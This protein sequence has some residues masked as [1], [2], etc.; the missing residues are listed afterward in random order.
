MQLGRREQGEE[1]GEAA[2]SLGSNNLFISRFERCVGSVVGLNTRGVVRAGEEEK[3]CIFWL[4][5][6]NTVK[7]VKGGC[8][9]QVNKAG[10]TN[11]WFCSVAAKPSSN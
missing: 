11:F 1:M 2:A 7:M 4:G 5:F 8:L 3:T 10:N 9:E 6:G